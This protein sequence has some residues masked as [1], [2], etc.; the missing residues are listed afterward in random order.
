M[1]GIEINPFVVGHVVC[2][3]FAIDLFE[4]HWHTQQLHNFARNY[5]CTHEKDTDVVG[6]CL[7]V[8]AWVWV[9]VWFSQIFNTAQHIYWISAIEF[10]ESDF[11]DF[12][13]NNKINDVWN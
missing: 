1:N 9:C 12:N 10:L 7:G 13:T 6:K 4:N 2:S 11:I 3:K 8:C 5:T